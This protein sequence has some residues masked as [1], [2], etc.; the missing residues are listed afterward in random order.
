MG[1]TEDEQDRLQIL[2]TTK[3]RTV[4]IW[5]SVHTETA[6]PLHCTDADFYVTAGTGVPLLGQKAKALEV[7]KIEASIAAI[8]KRIDGHPLVKCFPSVFNGV[9]K[10]KG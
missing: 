3:H 8:C 10:L 2:G 9:G 6:W 7:L 1:E 4:C 5:C